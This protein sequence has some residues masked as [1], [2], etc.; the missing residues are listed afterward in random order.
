MRRL[1]PTKNSFAS[2]RGVSSKV[3]KFG[4][5]KSVNMSTPSYDE[6]VAIA[7]DLSSKV[8]YVPL[9]G[10]KIGTD[11]GIAS[12][13]FRFSP[14]GFG[15]LCTALEVPAKFINRLAEDDA[16]L[17]THVLNKTIEKRGSGYR[18]A[19]A[20][21]NLVEGIVTG[22]YSTQLPNSMVAKLL[23]DLGPSVVGNVNSFQIEGL[24][25]RI[26]TVSD[27]LIQNMQ[28][29]DPVQGGLESI[30]AEDG[31]HSYGVSGY[32]YRLICT[33]GMIT[34]KMESVGRLVH[35]GS[36]LPEKAVQLIYKAAD[37]AIAYLPKIQNALPKTLTAYDQRLLSTKTKDRF[38]LAFANKVLEDA[39]TEQASYKREDMSLYDYWNGITVQAHDARSIQRTREIQMYAGEVL[40]YVPV[41][42]PN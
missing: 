41:S 24:R 1:V 37:S 21:G 3:F 36:S 25:M 2:R 32:I 9:T 13:G 18:V 23:R 39:G 26:T 34:G 27:K 12:H 15:R 5:S 17:A 42:S 33:N 29:G 16:E 19:V 30:N 7:D 40:D 8:Q 14:Y 11:G 6:M 22:D 35:R 38:S 31:G 28:K 10:M 4:Q 20:D